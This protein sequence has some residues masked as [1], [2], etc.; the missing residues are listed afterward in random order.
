M[1][2]P[3]FRMKR[4]GCPILSNEDIE[5]DAEYFIYDYDK[6]LLTDPR[7]VDIENFMEYYLGLTPEY[8][9]LT[10]CGLILGRMV[11]NNTNKLAVY[12]PNEKKADYIFAK[13]GTVVLDNTLLED[14]N[15]VCMR[16]TM[17]HECGHWIYHKAFFTL[18]P[19]GTRSID[20]ADQGI[21][22]CR[23]ADIFGSRHRLVTDHDWLEHQA[24]MFSACIL[25]PRSAFIR[26]VMDPKLRNYVENCPAEWDYDNVLATYAAVRFDVS[27]QSAR[28]RLFQLGVD[29]KS[30]M[31]KR[32]LVI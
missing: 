27:V 11:F 10:Q 17:G 25:M 18:S 22:A 19:N 2:I 24:K 5:R 14:R 23:E 20:I 16:S 12:V 8:A 21:T 26:Y 9:F 3:T 7:A 15:E 30:V 28:I 6:T 32:G 4:N 13:R 29:Y 1:Y 31:R